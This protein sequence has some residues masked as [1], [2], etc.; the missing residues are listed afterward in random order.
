MRLLVVWHNLNYD[1][2]YYKTIKSYAQYYYIGY[3]NQYNHQLILIIPISTIIPKSLH[4]SPVRVV[5]R[6]FISFLQK[7]EKKF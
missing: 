5:L 3:I 1:T 6:K 2:Y 7:L 4:V